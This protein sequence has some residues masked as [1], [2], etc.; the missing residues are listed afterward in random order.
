MYPQE[1]S[2]GLIIKKP[3]GGALAEHF[4]INK[5]FEMHKNHFYW[6]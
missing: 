1:S 4:G 3:H 5:T 2:K 6:P